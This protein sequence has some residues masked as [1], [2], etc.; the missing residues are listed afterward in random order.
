MVWYYSGHGH[1]FA[2][3][4][5]KDET[6]QGSSVLDEYDEAVGLQGNSDWLSDDELAG[7]LHQ[8]ADTITDPPYDVY[9]K[10]NPGESYYKDAFGRWLDFYDYDALSL[11]LS[12]L[13]SPLSVLRSA[14][15][16]ES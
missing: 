14:I 5:L 7:A 9:S 3:D 13:T 1:F 11:E 16:S 10:A 4:S 2:D 6:R 12:V 8:L 15:K